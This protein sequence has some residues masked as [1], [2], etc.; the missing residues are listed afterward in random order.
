MSG[1]FN[2][3]DIQQIQEQ[4]STVDAI[5]RQ[6]NLLEKGVTA[7]RLV[8][9]CTPE[10]GGIKVLSQEEKSRAQ[11]T[12]ENQQLNL[13]IKRFVPAS[14][15]ASRMF[16]S[17]LKHAKGKSSESSIE[18][19]QN[20][21]SFPFW[22]DV[23]RILRHNG[24][25]TDIK[26]LQE[27]PAVLWESMLIGGLNYA[28]MPKGMIPFHHY[29]DGSRTAFAEQ[30][31]ESAW[32]AENESGSHTHFTLP[33]AR[34][35]LIKYHLDD[36]VEALKKK[37]INASYSYSV[38]HSATDTIALGQ[39]NLP[40]REESGKLLFRPG[41]HGALIH[42]LSEIEADLVFIKN[43]DNVVPD[44]HKAK[45]LASKKVLAG[46]ALE[47]RDTTRDWIQILESTEN[48]DWVGLNTFIRESLMVRDVELN[49]IDATLRILQRPLRVC[50]MVKNEGE[51]GGG[52]FWVRM[53]DGS[54]RPQI[55]EMAQI[56]LDDP[57]QAS[58][59]EDSTHFNPVDIVALLKDHRG[60]N[61]DLKNF[62]DPEMAFISEK[63]YLGKS[64]KVLEHPG[65]WNGGMA[66]WN[67][68]FV[69]VPLD[70][71]NPVKTVNDLLR[72][73]H[74][75]ILAES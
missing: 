49:D 1:K 74:K 69:Q 65:L 39:D 57:E 72:P 45:A 36:V 43:I 7:P 8:A 20:L 53:P 18:F 23:E 28:D 54:V 50:G 59:V 5:E 52:P 9:A 32:Y 75:V 29:P 46:L 11:K 16:K 58:I 41:G 10:D 68:V 66:Y 13:L 19:L 42:N 51:P 6:A 31:N 21:E 34:I 35:G 40:F 22:S 56:N 24:H 64:I 73:A 14:G 25:P 55:I 63:S 4:G 30:L 71:F 38:Q 33:E 70:S 12:F 62:I 48:I 2:A 17:L 60:V 3:E 61:Y 67:T 27:N 37:N 15:A 26:F 47:I 44:A